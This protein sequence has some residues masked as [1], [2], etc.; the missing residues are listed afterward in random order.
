MRILT[1][2]LKN[3]LSSILPIRIGHQISDIIAIFI[4]YNDIGCVD[5]VVLLVIAIF[6]SIQFVLC[7]RDVGLYFPVCSADSNFTVVVMALSPNMA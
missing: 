6:V 3:I 7:K 2:I 1:E 4:L 5:I